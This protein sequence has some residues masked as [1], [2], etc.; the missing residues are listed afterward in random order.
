MSVMLS[1]T[2]EKLAATSVKLAAKTEYI[3]WRRVS[4]SVARV[5]FTDC[6]K[7]SWLSNRL[8]NSSGSNN[9]CTIADI[10][11]LV[12]RI[13]TK[14][15]NRLRSPAMPVKLSAT[16][17]KLAA[18][19]VKL[20]AKAKNS[21]SRRVSCTVARVVFTA[22]NRRS[23]L[24][25]CL[26]SSFGF[27]N[28][29]TIADIL[30]LVGIV[31]TKWLSSLW[32]PVMLLLIITRTSRTDSWLPLF[33]FCWAAAGTDLSVLISRSTTARQAN[34]IIIAS[35]ARTA[36]AI[37][38]PVHCWT[39]LAAFAVGFLMLKVVLTVLSEKLV[40]GKNFVLLKSASMRVSACVSPSTLGPV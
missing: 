24:R 10:V 13:S 16:V 6:N 31:S 18:M 7:L 11:S 40:V 26:N 4:C 12:G 22:W 37:E 14:P 32:I 1:A 25:N 20:A 39:L 21:S 28:V 38:Q 35:T 17:E 3:S 23:W 30:S 34:E 8:S 5:I 29:C 2:V 36:T 15:L 27:N 9:A 19:S 33:K